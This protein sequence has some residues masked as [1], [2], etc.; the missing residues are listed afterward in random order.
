MLFRGIRIAGNR[1]VA[2]RVEG[3]QTTERGG[4]D[5]ADCKLGLFEDE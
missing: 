5:D 2:I 1:N 3:W 4:R